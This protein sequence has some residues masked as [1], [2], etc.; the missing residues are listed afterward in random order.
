M[1]EQTAI[2]SRTLVINPSCAEMMGTA[3]VPTPSAVP[4]MMRD[5]PNKLP[6]VFEMSILVLLN[7]MSLLLLVFKLFSYE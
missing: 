7:R 5:P 3:N 6:L 2:M 1:S 4:A